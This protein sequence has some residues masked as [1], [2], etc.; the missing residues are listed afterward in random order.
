MGK[1]LPLGEDG[2]VVL[3]DGQ[4]SRDPQRATK[5]PVL[6]TSP[7]HHEHRPRI[8]PPIE[9]LAGAVEKWLA[10]NA[11]GLL[12]LVQIC[13]VAPG[14]A[15]AAIA[16][17]L[18]IERRTASKLF[19]A[20]EAKHNQVADI[21]CSDAGV[22]LMRIDSDIT[23]EAVKQCQAQG[24]A[25]LPVHDSLIVQAGHA[26]RAAE[27]MIRAFG[28]RFPQARGC[29]VRIKRNSIPHN[30]RLEGLAGEG[31]EKWAA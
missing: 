9:E 17:E 29:E 28:A 8:V 19:A 1:W 24:I 2:S 26:D 12:L 3:I 22:G 23:V 6:G 16:K 18:E 14:G 31:S 10:R 5:L 21:F 27:I 13:L 15:V 30:G 4:L 7:P 11:Q 20:I 25:L